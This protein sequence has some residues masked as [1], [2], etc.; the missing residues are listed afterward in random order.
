MITEHP[1]VPL[2]STTRRGGGKVGSISSATRAV[3]ADS[4]PARNSGVDVWTDTSTCSIEGFI[5]SAGVY[6]W[7]CQL[8]V[9]ARPRASCRRIR[10]CTAS[11]ITS[12][13]SVRSK[14]ISRERLHQLALP[15]DMQILIYA[16]CRVD[17]V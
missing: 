6:V 12:R 17:S 16:T 13:V 4:T 11:S 15:P 7:R 3:R 5:A 9:S 14:T 1:S 2:I 8:G 10:A